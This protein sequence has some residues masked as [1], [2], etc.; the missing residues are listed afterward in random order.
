[1]KID[2]HLPH[3]FAGSPEQTELSWT[4]NSES[5]GHLATVSQARFN[6]NL[7]V[8]SLPQSLFTAEY[9]E[10]LHRDVAQK[11][12]NLFQLSPSAVAETGAR[13]SQIMRREFRDSQFPRV[14]LYYVP[15]HVLG[16]LR[17]QTVHFRLTHRNNL[18]C[19]MSAA[20]SHSSIVRF[21]HSGIGTV[22]TCP[23]F[24]TRS[25]MAQ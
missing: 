5:T 7:V 11:E 6:S 24:P 19:L 21:A 25:T 15:D 20:F 8:D 9:F 3:R 1:M 4:E 23:A 13:S 14:F 2:F 22:R 16:D 17:T 18:P 10:W 12:Q